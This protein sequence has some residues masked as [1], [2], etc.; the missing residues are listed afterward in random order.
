[1]VYKMLKNKSA[2]RY[3]KYACIRIGAR[4]ISNY[5]LLDIVAYD[6]SMQI[7]T[8]RYEMLF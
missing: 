8:I 1:M 5:R 6:P 3:S 2:L 7:D 4:A